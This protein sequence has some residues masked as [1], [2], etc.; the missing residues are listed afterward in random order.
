M[1]YS[2]KLKEVIKKYETNQYNEFEF[3]ESLNSIVALITE[4]EYFE[5]RRFLHD[6]AEELERINYLVE[7]R[8]AREEYLKV[9][10]QIEKTAYLLEST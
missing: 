3:Q 8:F 5:L 9:I 4:Y 10:N 1:D 7:E 2:E 6:A